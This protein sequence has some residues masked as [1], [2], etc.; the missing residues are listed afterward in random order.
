MS[1]SVI[2]L[3]LRI[4]GAL[5]LLFFLGAITY[6]IYRDVQL[7]SR[8]DEY[9]VK[10]RGVLR[11]LASETEAVQYGDEYQLSV[12]SGIGRSPINLVVI[13]DEFTSGRHALITWSGEQWLVE[14]VGSR[15][16]TFLNDLPVESQTVIVAGDVITVGRT[17]FKL[18][19]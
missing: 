19:M 18:D 7:A 5:L 14:D 12:V 13:D 15:N 17:Q 10:P 9:L 16:G 2:L 6:F 3:I 4:T 8:Q 11:V 1:P